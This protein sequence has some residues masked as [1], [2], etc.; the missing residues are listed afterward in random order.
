MYS[1]CMMPKQKAYSSKKNIKNF[2]ASMLKNWI[3]LL[4]KYEKWKPNEKL[5]INVSIFV[6]G[7][8]R[9]FLLVRYV[10]WLRV[11]R[12]WLNWIDHWS[13][14]LDYGLIHIWYSHTTHKSNVQWISISF[15]W[16]YMFK[17][18]V[19]MLNCLLI[20]P[21]NIFECFIYFLKWFL[22]LLF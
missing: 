19:C 1:K 8:I 14:M 18:D 11:I 22:S 16:L 13:F 17:C 9:A 10:T 5:S 21:K 4:K 15:M 2:M 7:H 20:K 6:R 12:V 3:V